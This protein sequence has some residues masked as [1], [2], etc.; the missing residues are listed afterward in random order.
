MPEHLVGDGTGLVLQLLHHRLH[1]CQVLSLGPLLVHTG[2][3]MTGTHV[4]EVVVQDVVVADVT[5]GVDHRVGIFLTVLADILTTIFKIG[6]EHAFQLNT[7]HVAPLGF[8]R[9]IQQITFGIALHLAVGH[10]L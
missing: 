3:E 10:P 1:R 7:H 6:V 2:N 9:E 4:V 8:L 5:L